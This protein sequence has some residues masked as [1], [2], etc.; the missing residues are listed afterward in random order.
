[1]VATSNVPGAFSLSTLYYLHPDFYCLWI[2]LFFFP[3]L[4][5]RFI[6]RLLRLLV[7]SKAFM[8]SQKK[9]PITGEPTS[10]CLVLKRIEVHIPIR[11][12]PPRPMRYARNYITSKKAQ[13]PIGLLILAI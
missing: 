3:L 10:R 13:E 8:P 4:R 1:M 5:K 11:E 6:P 12:R 7:F 2:L 9:C